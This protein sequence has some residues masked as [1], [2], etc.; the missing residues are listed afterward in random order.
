[1]TGVRQWTP[2]GA[3]R[4]VGQRVDRPVTLDEKVAAVADLPRD[5]EV[6]AQVATD[7][8][9]RPEVT[10]HVT[11]AE[12]MRV[13]TELPRDDDT[14]REVPRDMPPTPPSPMSR[15]RTL[16]PVEACRTKHAPAH[17]RRIRP[18]LPHRVTDTAVLSYR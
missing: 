18:H 11:P 12:K 8:L 9:K 15:A 5:D 6:T 13:V 2:D 3:K 7:L 17:P 16:L 14:A 1:M 10:E 4:V